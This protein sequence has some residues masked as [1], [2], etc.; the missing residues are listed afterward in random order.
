[1]WLSRDAKPVESARRLELERID[2]VDSGPC[3]PAAER[4]FEALERRSIPL[5]HDLDAAVMLIA[6]EPLNAFALRRVLDEEPEP[7][8]LNTSSNDE[9]TPDEHGK[10]YKGFARFKRFEES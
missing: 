6:N 4:H 7:H 10:L 8:A 9:A 1:V 2:V 3:R 5:G